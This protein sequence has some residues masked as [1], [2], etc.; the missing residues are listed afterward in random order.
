MAEKI[1][2]KSLD[3]DLQYAV[4]R[5]TNFIKEY[6]AKSKA[7]GY[8][9]GLSGGIDS[10]TTLAL[11]VKAVGSE[12]ITGLIMPFKGITPEEDINDALDLANS[13]NVKHH[14][15]CINSIFEAFKSI[16]P[17]FD[18]QDRISN[19]N[20]MARTRMILLYYY[21][22][23]YNYLVVG[24]GDKSEILLGY[25]TKGGDGMVDI[26][27][28]GDL[29]KTQVRKVA[30]YLGLPERIVTKPSSPRLWAGQIAE[31]ELGISYE[32]IDLVLYSLFDLRLSMDEIAEKTGISKSVI[33]AIY[34]RVISSQHKRSLPPIPRI[35]A[36]TTGLDL[37]MPI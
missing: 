23:K 13:F 24:T 36:R 19:G 9:I 10:S 8:V 12:K 5:I 35:S 20:L 1:T 4:E 15:I 2:I 32:T 7:K 30:K 3:I 22:N 26:L 17:Y 14:I 21:A 6:L 18:E 11:L 37:R 27:P 28:I 33:Q 16:I 29:Y 25:F 34:E 31:Q